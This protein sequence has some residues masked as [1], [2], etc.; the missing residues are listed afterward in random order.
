MSAQRGL[1]IGQILEMLPHRSPFVMVDRVTE[2]V[3][4]ES[5]RGY[6]NV[7]MNEPWFLGH[8]PGHPVM[9]GVLLIEALAQLGGIL[10][11]ASGPE[12][13][14]NK[15]LYFLAIDKARFRRPVVPGDRLDLEVHV[16]QRRGG[17]WR[18]RG[19]ARVDG[20]TCAEGELL[21]SAVERTKQ[22]VGG[23]T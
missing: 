23:G 22:S 3:P 6:K 10:A 19:E 20:A 8:F 12:E 18:L 4:N 14:R 9:P 16:L 1:D 13:D 21:T 7:A 2:V 15:L 11:A 17:A 5:I